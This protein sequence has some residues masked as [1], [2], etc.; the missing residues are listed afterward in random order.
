MK[1]SPGSL[2][3]PF[4]CQMA[5]GSYVP[6]F[7]RRSQERLPGLD[8]FRFRPG[9]RKI[10]IAAALALFLCAAWLLITRYRI[11]LPSPPVTIAVL[12]FDDL[13]NDPEKGGLS[14][15]KLSYIYLAL[16]D[17]ESCFRCLERDYEQRDPELPYINADPVFDSVR[18]HPRFIAF[19]KRMNLR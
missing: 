6:T 15:L 11:P 10:S 18:T 17:L 9:K 2:E 12:P 14:D 19:L 7:R 13:S 16:G 1:T 5:K 4:P 3:G 8:L